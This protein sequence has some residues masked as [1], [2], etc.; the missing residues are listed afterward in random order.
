MHSMHLVDRTDALVGRENFPDDRIKD[1][2]QHLDR[3][4]SLEVDRYIRGF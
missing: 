4:E 2:L 3:D 1:I